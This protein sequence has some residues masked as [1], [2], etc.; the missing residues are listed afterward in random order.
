M[1]TLKQSNISTAIKVALLTICIF[2]SFGTLNANAASN[3]STANT[4]IPQSLKQNRIKKKLQSQTDIPR[5][6][7]NW[8]NAREAENN[9]LRLK[10]FEHIA[11]VNTAEMY[12]AENELIVTFENAKEILKQ[13]KMDLNKDP[14]FDIDVDPITETVISDEELT[15]VPEPSDILVSTLTPSNTSAGMPWSDLTDTDL[16]VNDTF[17]QLTSNFRNIESIDDLEK[18]EDIRGAAFYL[19]GQ[20]EYLFTMR[21]KYRMDFTS[22]AEYYV[23]AEIETTSGEGILEF[24]NITANESNLLECA[25]DG[26]TEFQSPNFTIKEES[27]ID[28]STLLAIRNLSA[29]T[30]GG[31]IY[32]LKLYQVL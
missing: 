14:D 24:K 23:I 12:S 21:A 22:D 9:P 26:F 1:M 4:A 28:L 27:L 7:I 3:N 2:F 25:A 11:P 13:L 30:C 8:S 20:N 6:Q 18:D 15:D 10:G 29:S 17:S 31:I 32:S 19:S 16:Y 5:V